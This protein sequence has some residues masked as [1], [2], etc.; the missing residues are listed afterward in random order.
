MN[1]NI[2]IFLDIKS[3]KGWKH[4]SL[5]CASLIATLKSKSFGYVE[6]IEADNLAEIESRLS[7]LNYIYKSCKNLNLLIG[8]YIWSESIVSEI[9]SNIR[10]NGFEGRI[11]LGGPSVTYRDKHEL[12]KIFPE[13]DIFVKGYAEDVIYDILMSSDKLKI[14][15]V[16]YNNSKSKFEILTNIDICKLASPWLMDIIHLEEN[17]TSIN[18]ET[19][20]GC[21][22]NCAYCQYHGNLHNNIH[23]KFDINRIKGEIDLF[24]LKNIGRIS[25]V[26]PVFYPD[27]YSIE[28][29]EYFIRIGYR[30][31]LC[32]HLRVE[33]I[34][35]DFIDL[36][37]RLNTCLEIGLQTIFEEESNIINR[38]NDLVKFEKAIY[39]LNKRCIDYEVS[40]LYGL[41]GQTYNS[42][43]KT[44]DFLKKNN[45]KK[46]RAFPLSIFPGTGLEKKME[47]YKIKI[48]KK[49]LNIVVSTY[50]FS[51]EEY[52]IMENVA[53]KINRKNYSE[54]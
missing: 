22:Y 32:L 6:V 9:L 29:L 42:F 46:I 48:D 26:D 53:L 3:Q 16:S 2:A 14:S 15:G 30:G 19:R 5:G 43:S 1:N 39:E 4:L 31:K 38:K 28:I 45:V 35:D 25:V 52:H 20:R 12:Q 24:H 33:L 10:K 13:A 51:E 27:K 23:N 50:S 18:W 40:I 54:Q 44:I 49:K 37:N 17:H 34:K 47:E 41:P 36:F 21:P 7:K 11:I 8:V